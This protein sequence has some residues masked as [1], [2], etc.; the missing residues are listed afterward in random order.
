[1][2]SHCR[3][4]SPVPVVHLVMPPPLRADGR[5]GLPYARASGHAGAVKD[6]LQQQLDLFEFCVLH[7]D[8]AAAEAVLDD[9]YALVLV[10]P[11]YAR[12][13]R[14]RWI[15]VLPEYIVQSYAVE[16]LQLDVDGE[17][18]AV[19]QRV[20]MTATVLGQD[21]SGTFVMSDIWRRRPHGWRLWRRHSTPLEAGIMPGADPPP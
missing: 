1:M 8:V 15:E 9:S 12:M 17:T 2:L 4:G 7:R 14:A 20:R 5:S 21:R 13:P 16:E 19:L 3:E 11:A 6:D 18:A 10:A